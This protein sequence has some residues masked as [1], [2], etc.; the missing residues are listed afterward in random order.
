[1]GEAI[2]MKENK[3]YLIV[4]LFLLFI[5]NITFAQDTA[6][7]MCYNLENYT[8]ADTSMNTYFRT[9][10]AD[11]KPDI[12]VVEEIT[13]QMA[14]DIFLN[15]V[16]K[17][18]DPNYKAGQFI[19]SR[20]YYYKDSTSNAL[21]FNSAK[22]NFISNTPVTTDQR[23]INEFR[24]VHKTSNDTI[25][26]FG[27]HLNAGQPDSTSRGT[28]IDNLR[29][30]TDQFPPRTDYLVLGDFNVYKGSEAAAQK[31]INKTNSGYFLDPVNQIGDW[32][33]NA[34]YASIHT[35]STRSSSGGLDDRFDLIFIS[36]AVNDTGGITYVNNSYTSYGNDGQHFN[37]S[38]NEP[39][40]N[41]AVSAQIADALYYASDHLPVY[42][43]FQFDKTTYVK[44]NE[45]TAPQSF[46]LF[47]NYPNPFNPET[48]IR[49][50]IARGG[51]VS[52][53]VYDVLGREV[54]DLVNEEKPPGEYEV[55]FSVKGGSAYRGNAI[56]LNEDKT[57][58]SSG[59]YFYQ[60]KA[61]DFVQTKKFILMK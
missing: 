3:K 47:Q 30:I 17:A 56:N 61:G 32:H 51:Y 37:L 34:A 58:I 50:R 55:I 22:F 18:F 14:V 24:L 38:I 35:Q 54:A 16:L 26:V 2:L 60:L 46:E 27:V 29:T 7:I 44:E 21:F 42:A 10:L 6:K 43:L 1:M 23:D 39:P 33:N 15:N 4:L 41:A 48:R 13:S 45:N 53:K 25:T 31:L 57:G 28:E 36:Q 52:L 12:L 40:P 20:E 49:F 8:P 9:I 19:K 5:S 11:I 59:I